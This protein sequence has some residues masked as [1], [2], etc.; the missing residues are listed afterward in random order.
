[1]AV[2]FQYELKIRILSRVEKNSTTILPSQRRG[3][4]NLDFPN[5]A[6]KRPCSNLCPTL[7]F[8]LNLCKFLQATRSTQLRSNLVCFLF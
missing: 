1:M 6:S 3:S 2:T 4:E 5:S 8:M 7:I